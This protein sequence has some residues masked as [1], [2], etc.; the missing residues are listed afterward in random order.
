MAVKQKPNL[1]QKVTALIRNG[2]K[3]ELA[4]FL[5][6]LYP[7]D[8]APIIENLK[9]EEK[10]SSFKVLELEN[11]A[12][13]FSEFNSE[14]QKAM[15]ELL[16]AESVA[17]IVSEM[18]VDDATDLIIRLPEEEKAKLLKVLPDPVQQAHVQELINYPSESAGGI[19]S[20]DFLK[21]R[22]DMTVHIA[23]NC[24]RRQA[25]EYKAQIYYL[26]V[27]DNE[28]KLVGVISLR[29]LICAP[30]NDLVANH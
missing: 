25:A 28:N 3:D 16:G 4:D 30:L 5:N 10:I 6:D 23:F 19:M 8:L 17:Q 18:D 20:T 12:K 11:A 26:Y 27:V 1:I 2:E 15:L 9:D 29:D 21:L 24:V 14:M 22:S 13:V 7:Q